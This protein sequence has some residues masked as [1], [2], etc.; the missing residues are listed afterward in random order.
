LP[1]WITQVNTITSVNSFIQ[2]YT[3]DYKGSYEILRVPCNFGQVTTP[4]AFSFAYDDYFFINFYGSQL[5]PTTVAF[6]R[7]KIIPKEKVYF[8][9]SNNE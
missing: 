5:N 1:L 6:V 2:G 3:A 7:L 4:S 9:V 8:E